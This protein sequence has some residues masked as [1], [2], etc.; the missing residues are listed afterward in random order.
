MQSIKKEYREI[1]CSY[2][3][4]TY[5]TFIPSSDREEGESFCSEACLN[6]FLQFIQGIRG[7]KK[8]FYKGSDHISIESVASLVQTFALATDTDLLLSLILAVSK[9]KTLTQLLS[10]PHLEQLENGPNSKDKTTSSGKINQIRYYRKGIQQFEERKLDVKFTETMAKIIKKTQEYS[11]MPQ[12]PPGL[13]SA[14]EE[15]TRTLFETVLS[16][17][18]PRDY[19]EVS[20]NKSDST[21]A[22]TVESNERAQVTERNALRGDEVYFFDLNGLEEGLMLLKDEN[23]DSWEVNLLRVSGGSNELNF[24]RLENEV[25]EQYRGLEGVSIVEA[26]GNGPGV[27]LRRVNR[28][29]PLVPVEA[30]KLYLSKNIGEHMSIGDNFTINFSLEAEAF[31]EP[32]EYFYNVYNKAGFDLVVAKVLQELNEHFTLEGCRGEPLIAFAREVVDG[33]DLVPFFLKGLAEGQKFIR[34]EVGPQDLRVDLQNEAFKALYWKEYTV[35]KTLYQE[36]FNNGPFIK[37]FADMH[38]VDP[39]KISDTLIQEMPSLRMVQ[40][41]FSQLSDLDIFNGLRILE[42]CSAGPSF[43]P[44]IDS[45]TNTYYRLFSKLL[46]LSKANGPLKIEKPIGSK[47]S[48]T[49]H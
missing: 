42:S 29:E 18:S 41:P 43:I 36:I 15:I 26:S 33:V 37:K 40:R 47:F 4:L 14:H 49:K 45:M 16:L 5:N 48:L 30:R 32:V 28:F 35:F 3:Q 21:K 9:A 20:K 25:T 23:R 17:T 22:F 7:S 11:S 12:V 31:L 46:A 24:G 19:L 27:G 44:A 2:C 6:S 38:K 1:A 8:L 13:L 10:D 39:R 34:F